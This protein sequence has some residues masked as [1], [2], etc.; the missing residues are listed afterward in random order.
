MGSKANQ[1]SDF[2]YIL[3]TLTSR[4]FI[5]V[6]EERTVSASDEG[7]GAVLSGM[8]VI[9]VNIVVYSVN[10]HAVDTYIR[11]KLDSGWKRSL[12]TVFR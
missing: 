5:E 7:I 8:V 4:D 11:S 2:R 6:P 1:K 12:Q 3:D 9:G 10:L